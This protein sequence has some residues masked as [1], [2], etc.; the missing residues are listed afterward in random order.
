MN[1]LK[2]FLMLYL[3]LILLG[4]ASCTKHTMVVIAPKA[5][6]KSVPPGQAKKAT[7]SQS[8][9]QYAPGQQKKKN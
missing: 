3:V 7:G 2:K 4:T 1:K 6:A 9:K 5:P 8:A